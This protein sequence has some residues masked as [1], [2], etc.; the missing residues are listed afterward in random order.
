M[1]ARRLS[2]ALTVLWLPT[3]LLV[4]TDIPGSSRE[5]FYPTANVCAAIQK[6]RYVIT[7]AVFQSCNVVVK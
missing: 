5:H 2:R 3:L 1:S 7:Q 6:E 4:S